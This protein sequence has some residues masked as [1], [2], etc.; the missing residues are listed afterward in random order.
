MGTEGRRKRATVASRLIE[1]PYQFDFF[2]A[3]EESHRVP[4]GVV[5]RHHLPMSNHKLSRYHRQTKGGLNLI[6][7]MIDKIDNNNH[8]N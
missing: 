4:Q 6:K 7:V 1:K 2:Q 8:Q 3:M 5:L